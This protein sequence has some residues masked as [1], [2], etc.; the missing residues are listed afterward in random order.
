MVRALILMAEGSENSLQRASNSL[1]K[2]IEL[3]EKRASLSTLLDRRQC[4]STGRGLASN[5]RDGAYASGSGAGGSWPS[6]NGL[7][8]AFIE[9]GC[10]ME[11]MLRALGKQPEYADLVRTLLN[12]FPAD[13]ERHTISVA[14]EALP[15][16]LTGRELEVL[17][18]LAARLSNKEIAQRL[19]VS[20]HTV[21]NQTSNIFGK[22]QVNSRLQ[23]VAVG[24][25]LGLIPTEP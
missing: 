24:R 16:P 21:R 25:E 19:V 13:S 17:C 12:T 6:L 8:G 11:G 7:A 5:G 10:E 23:A 18:L 2:M 4:P 3:A 22:L 1:D 20:T 9:R 15:E 14:L